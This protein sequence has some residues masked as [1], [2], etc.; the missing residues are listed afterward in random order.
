M[1]SGLTNILCIESIKRRVAA[2]EPFSG[3]AHLSK[4][5]VAV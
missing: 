5:D 1:V 3:T 2:Y 4:N